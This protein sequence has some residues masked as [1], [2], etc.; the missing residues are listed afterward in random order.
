VAITSSLESALAS[1][2]ATPV[3]APEP[4]ES[5]PD[6]AEKPPVDDGTYGRGKDIPVKQF[7]VDQIDQI[8]LAEN[9]APDVLDKLGSLVL[10]EF[11]LDENSRSDWKDKADKAMKFALQ[12][13]EEKQYP[14]PKACC[15]LDTDILTQS[16]WKP[17]GDVAVGENVLSRAPDGTAAFFPVNKTYRHRATEVVHFDGK[18]I[19][20]LVTPNHRMLVQDRDTGDLDF[21]EA[22]EFVR[23]HKKGPN[24]FRLS[25][26]SIPLTSSWH[27]TEPAFVYGI[28]AKAYVRFLGWFVSEGYSLS[29]KSN[30]HT[31]KSGE[32]VD[33]GAS[34]SSFGIAQSKSANPEKYEQIRRDIEACGF[35]Y[36]AYDK[37]FI[38]HAKSMPPLFKDE[39]RAMGKVYGKRLPAHVLHYH[40]ELLKQLLETMIAGDGHIRRRSRQTMDVRSYFTTSR[41]LADQVQEICQKIGLRGT[42]A[43]TEARLGGVINGRQITG[44]AE[45]YSISILARKTIQVLKLKREL[46]PYDQDVACVEVEPHH[47]IF[48][49]RNGKAVWVGNSNIIFPLI[50]QAA[51]QFNARTYPAVIQNRNVVKG[52]IWGTDKGTPATEDG[53]LEGKPKMHPDGTPV[54]LSAPG[55][56][57]KRADRIGEHMSW[58]LLDQMKEWEGQTDGMLIQ[59]PIIGGACRKTYRDPIEGRNRSLLVKLT[60]LVWNYHA[61]TFEDAPRH[62]EII[63]LYPHQIEENERAEVYLPLIY[64][65]GGGDDE[66]NSEQA[67]SGDEDAPHIFL[68]Q[69]RR[70]DLDGDGYPEP[71]VVTIH[72]RSAKVV[73]IVARYDE[74]G[75]QTGK[76]A[77]VDEDSE[78]G[79]LTDDEGPDEEEI[80]KIIPVEH[81]TLIPF[82]PN[83]DGGSYPVGF[84]HLLRPLNEAINTTLNQM[85][86]AGHLQNAGGGFVSDQLSIHSGP[87]GFQVGKYVRVGSKGQAIR[88]AVFPIPFPGP[89]SVLFQLLGALVKVSE[90]VA[91]TQEILAG[92]AEMANAP[93]TT[94]LALIEQGLKVYTAIHKRVYRALKA[95][96]NKIYRLNRLYLKENERY[97]VGDE[98]REIT[99]DDYRL[100]GGVEPIADPTMVT[101]MQKLGRA[102]VG[103]Q[104]KG[105]PLIDQKNIYTRLFEA[106]G[107]DRIE[108]MFTPPPDP[109]MTQ[110]LQ[111][112]AMEEKQAEL[113]RLRAAELKDNSQAYLN[114]AMAASKANGPQMDWINAQLRVMEMHIEATNTMV[115]AADV[116]SKHRLGVGRLSNEAARNRQDV[117]DLGDTVSS[118]PNAN[119]PFPQMPAAPIAPP[120]PAP[121]APGGGSPALPPLPTPSASALAAVPPPVPPLRG[122][123]GLPQ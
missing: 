30:I 69:H 27:G 75:I 10:F 77:D 31:L 37:F 42:I 73:R 93:P 116:E 88:D 123:G 1:P 49:R 46:I 119:T 71:Y 52:T 53:K 6:D 16:G 85:F 74:D 34:T 78:T 96:F 38:V 33:Y 32:V 65:P 8:N 9:Y 121:A 44:T 4:A 56:K 58:Q 120:T 66:T 15:S 47:T 63:T 103:M 91:G 86:D 2:T 97:Q 45:G 118:A 59:L 122:N 111:A 108:E 115:K 12:E 28:A 50:T 89:S 22:G 82:L 62:T 76:G 43:V 102:S 87:V 36:K 109:Q 39:L 100:G 51:I 23:K 90:G 105:D 19:D 101:D 14:W 107:F 40:P 29:V 54:W 113:G 5:T 3:P 13:A 117:S 64:G 24:Q 79:A 80:L 92:G 7:L 106:A 68:E 41:L 48:V 17:I 104:F 81:Y 84:G 67:Q 112:M 20:L 98:W 95:E 94:I 57:R 61:P 11:N 99:L 110:Q 21:I 114:M 25:R 26:Q 35:T 72:K 18:S 55:E 60:N 83:P 70:Y